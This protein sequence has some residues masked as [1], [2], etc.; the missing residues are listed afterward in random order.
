MII[1]ISD[2]GVRGEG[3]GKSDAGFV[4][5]VPGSLPGEV[6]EVEIEQKNK[7]FARASLIKV[8]EPSKYRVEPTCPLFS[9]CGGCQLQHLSY[10]GQVS[11]K[12]NLVKE[13]LRR[14][15]GLDC[16]VLPTKAAEQEWFYR[17]KAQFP[18]GITSDHYP[19]MGFYESGSHNLVDVDSC[20]IQSEKINRVFAEIKALF[21]ET[22]PSIY[23]E[24][25]H[26][27]L[28][29]H[30]MLRYSKSLDKVAV[31]FVINS[32][33]YKSLNLYVKPLSKL[34]D[35]AMISANINTQKGNVVLGQ[36]SVLLF[37]EETWQETFFDT[38]FYL[39]L[40]SFLQV[41]TNQAAVLFQTVLDMAELSEHDRVWDLYCGIG[42]LT[43]L[44]SR[45]VK[46][47]VGIERSDDS[48]EWAKK[49][50][51]N[52]QASNVV[53]LNEDLDDDAVFTKTLKPFDPT[54]VILDPPRKGCSK[55]VLTGLLTYL[56]QKV[57][58]VSCDPA[59][60]ARDLS[61]LASHYEV[62]CV[63]PIDLFP[64]TAHIETVVLLSRK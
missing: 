45:Q 42:I 22:P 41:N 44:M 56:P 18:V 24:A 63:Q 14:I 25:N 15:G 54:C 50:A 7:R 34:A 48:I 8:I 37:G 36:E 5:F 29:R 47:V 58:Y 21:L 62:R 53:F 23:N 49:N 39:S 27:G 38:P 19:V 28:V 9:K 35:I 12:R 1:Q 6:V 52:Q 11:W 40:Q 26:K 3:I 46:S 64:Q 43:L 51:E 55:A 31:V 16:D 32:R 20:P 30:V 4:V 59:T 17:N 13:A 61:I 2:L 33:S 10:N 57:I 60:L